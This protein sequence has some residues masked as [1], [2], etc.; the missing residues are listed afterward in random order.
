MKR[1]RM[2]MCIA[3]LAA[4][5]APSIARA[6]TITGTWKLEPAEHGRQAQLQL[7]N[8]SDGFENTLHWNELGI[9]LSSPGSRFELRREAGT[10]EFTGTIADGTGS[11]DFTFT[12]SDAFRSGLS[13]RGLQGD[14]RRGMTAACVDLTLEYIDTIH[15]TGY[16]DLSFDN[17]V[18]FRALDVTPASIAQLRTLFGDLPAEEVISTSALRIT[19]AYVEEL[20][21]MGIGPVT[22]QQA[23]TFKSLRIDKAYVGELAGM[24]YRNMRPNDIVAFKALHIDAAYLR[25]L[26]SHGL[27]N[28]TPQQVIEMKATGL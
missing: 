20:R 8:T 10:F 5:V 13:A 6:N 11:G 28:L 21:S 24:G 19:R 22:A 17:L 26:A 23:V 7:Y 15:A 12:P 1:L 16:R 3:M 27:K 4:L 9:Q 14:D 18:A 25:H 2:M